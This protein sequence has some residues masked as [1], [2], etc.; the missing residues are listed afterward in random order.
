MITEFD[1]LTSHHFDLIRRLSRQ[2]SQPDHEIHFLDQSFCRV[3]Q[4]L[5]SLAHNQEVPAFDSGLCTHL[6]N[7]MKYDQV[8]LPPPIK[9][10]RSTTRRIIEYPAYLCLSEGSLEVRHLFWEQ[11]HEGSIPSLPTILVI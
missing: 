3:Y 6:S 7:G 9:W 2:Y 8:E 11:D 4:W 5:D 1:S 10:R